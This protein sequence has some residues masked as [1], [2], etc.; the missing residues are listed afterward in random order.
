MIKYF[1]T[2]FHLFIESTIDE[3]M[4]YTPACKDCI[5]RSICLETKTNYKMKPYIITRKCSILHKSLEE[6]KSFVILKR[7]GISNG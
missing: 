3:F 7:K 6:N 5:V 2:V 4:E 1:T